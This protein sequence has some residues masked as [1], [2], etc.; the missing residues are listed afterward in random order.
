[1]SR[2]FGYFEAAGAALPV[3]APLDVVVVVPG[4]SAGLAVS[5]PQATTPATA[6]AITRMA[7]MVS[8]FMRILLSNGALVVGDF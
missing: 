7:R 4:L 2:S 3:G 8:F 1:M 5:P 6:P